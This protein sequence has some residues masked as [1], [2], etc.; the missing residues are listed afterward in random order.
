[1]VRFFVSSAYLAL[2]S[3]LVAYGLPAPGTYEISQD[4]QAIA[5]SNLAWV[6]NA[7]AG[8]A[9]EPSK[10]WVVKPGSKKGWFSLQNVKSEGHLQ[11]RD[12]VGLVYDE[13]STVDLALV[14]GDKPDSFYVMT[15]EGK[16][17]AL[18]PGVGRWF[19]IDQSPGPITLRTW[20]DRESAWTFRRV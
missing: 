13:K 11:Y 15:K 1:M 4:G 16:F 8:G 6:V 12:D 5:T 7:K 20:S 14:P 2:A 17:L 19:P 18:Q 3:A 10:T 9:A